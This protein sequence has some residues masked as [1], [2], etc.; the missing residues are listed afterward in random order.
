MKVGIIG[1]GAIGLLAAAYLS[2]NHT[3]SVFVKSNNQKQKLNKYGVKCGAL[4]GTVEAY[5][6]PE[7]LEIQDLLIVTVKQYDVHTIIKQLPSNVP[8]LFL[9]NGMAHLNLLEGLPNSCAVGVVEHGAVRMSEYEVQHTGL[10]MIHLAHFKGPLDVAALTDK[11]SVHNFR[12]TFKDD[13]WLMLAEKLV[14]NTVINP[15]TALFGVKNKYVITN[16]CLCRLAKQLCAEAS[17]TLNLSFEEQWDRV[18]Q[19]AERTGANQSSMLKDLLEH[20]HTEVD[21]ICGFILQHSKEKSP[22]HSFVVDAIH[23]LEIKNIKGEAT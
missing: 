7:N 14:I 22:Y 20:R 10:G 5:N 18:K 16:P 21:A 1:G 6:N 15:L 17:Q 2:Q 12:F 13:Y 23:A 9:Q 4:C 19:I 11:L 8:C 3:V